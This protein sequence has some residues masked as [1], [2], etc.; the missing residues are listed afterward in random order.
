MKISK[1]IF[2]IILATNIFLIIL[3]FLFLGYTY[4]VVGTRTY[5]VITTVFIVFLGIV[6]TILTIIYVKKYDKKE[7]SQ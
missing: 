4:Y 5:D 1:S 2:K 3:A 6:F 7:N